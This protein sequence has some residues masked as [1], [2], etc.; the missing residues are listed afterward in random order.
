MS[1]GQ[2]EQLLDHLD[3]RLRDDPCDHTLR[4]TRRW[5]Q[6]NGLGADAVE[7]GYVEMGAGCDCEVRDNLDP[8]L[9]VL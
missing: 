9:N 7:E 5:A 6:E 2:H 3:A 1:P 8:E 4:H